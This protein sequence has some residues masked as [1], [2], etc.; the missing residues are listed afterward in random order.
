MRWFL[1]QWQS[2][3]PAVVGGDNLGLDPDPRGSRGILCWS[4][5]SSLGGLCLHTELFCFLS[6]I[7]GQSVALHES[8]CL[9]CGRKHNRLPGKVFRPLSL[10]NHHSLRS[11]KGF[12]CGGKQS[13]CVSLLLPPCARNLVMSLCQAQGSGSSCAPLGWGEGLNL[14]RRG[15]KQVVEQGLWWVTAQGLGERELPWGL[16][17][18]ALSWAKSPDL[19]LAL[20]LSHWNRPLCSWRFI[21]FP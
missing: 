17:H 12:L 9:P 3:V 4:Q 19:P 14:W 8:P 1:G 5:H 18:I 10:E 20:W 7:S 16:C 21:R 11:F 15:P 6:N 13:W 2:L